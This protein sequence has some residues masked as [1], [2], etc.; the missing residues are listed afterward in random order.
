MN[1]LDQKV[2]G[3]FKVEFKSQQASFYFWLNV[4][5]ILYNSDLRRI[6]EQQALESGEPISDPI[7]FEEFIEIDESEISADENCMYRLLMPESHNDA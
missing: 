7:H 3:D 4:S 5:A 2:W 1:L 6:S